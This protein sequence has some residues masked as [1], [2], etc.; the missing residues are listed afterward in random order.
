[1]S[2]SID[3]T[4]LPWLLSQKQKLIDDDKN[5]K[6]AFISLWTRLCEIRYTESDSADE[7]TISEKMLSVFELYKDKFNSGFYLNM[8]NKLAETHEAETRTKYIYDITYIHFF[9]APTPFSFN[10]FTIQSEEKTRTLILPKDQVKEVEKLLKEEGFADIDDENYD[11]TRYFDAD[12]ETNERI[13]TITA[14]DPDSE[15]YYT[16]IPF[17]TVPLNKII[18][19]AKYLS[20]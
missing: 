20:K 18:R 14:S 11:L 16:A 19:V 10:H 4:I 5:K 2:R 6:K 9:L 1:M 13:F 7:E 3:E 15:T 17:K 8:C 12:G